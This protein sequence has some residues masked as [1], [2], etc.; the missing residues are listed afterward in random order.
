MT[1]LVQADGGWDDG[2]PDFLVDDIP[3]PDNLPDIV[4]LSDGRT[5]PVSVVQTATNS[6]PVTASNLQVQLTANFPAGFVYLVVPDP[7]HGQFPLQT[8]L[9]T[10][11]TSFLTNDFWQTDRT[12]GPQGLPPVLETNLHLFVYHTNAG[13]DTYNIVY[14]IPT[15]VLVTNPPVSSVFALPPQSPPMFGVV[16][17][18]ASYAGGS[19]IAYYDIYVS[20]NGGSFTDWQGHTSGTGALYNGV[21]GHTYAF[22]SIATDAA[23]HR[24]SPPLQPQAVT[25]ITVNTNPPTLSVASNATLTAGQTL[26]LNVTASDPNPLSPLTFSLGA[27]APAGVQFNPASGQVTW[28]TSPAFGGTTNLLSIVVQDNGQPPLSATGTVTVVLLPAVYPPV[29][30]VQQSGNT[31][32]KGGAS[33]AFGSVNLGA[34]LPESFIINNGGFGALVLSNLAITGGNAGDFQLSPISLPS[35]VNPAGATSFTVTFTPSRAGPESA[36]LRLTDNDTNNNP[37]T[38]ALIGTGL[39]VPPA[40][41]LTGPTNDTGFVTPINLTLS[42]TATETDGAVTNVVF[43]R[44]ATPL[45]NVPITPF[46]FTLTNAPA[47]FY[48]LTAV[49]MDDSGASSTSSVVNVLVTNPPPV[50]GNAYYTRAANAALL[51]TISDL[52][53]N[54]TGTNGETIT[55]VGV[56]T[57]GLNLLSTNGTTLLNN[58]RYILYTNSVTPGVNDRFNYLVGDGQGGSAMG[59]VYIIV[60]NNIIGQSNVRL[61]FTSTNV[62]ANFFGVPGFKY[63]AERSTNLSVGLGWVP[64]STNVAPTNGL[65]QVTDGFQDLGIPIPPLPPQVFYLLRASP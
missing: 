6:G 62:T 7:A 58:G 50:A 24:E 29:L 32:L 65:I 22:Y 51:I 46:T 23:G 43:Y 28:A 54:V 53:T 10:N 21:N 60:N 16:W 31:L 12:F 2:L 35:V 17:S 37:F 55:L 8:V 44:G 63:T 52:L 57:D 56:G 64:I 40:V 59:T 14:R 38:V 26:S 41:T 45:G 34:N 15:N 48:A 5:Q 11:G 4:Y 27:G 20:D 47:G 61:T 33:V 25:A 18:G 42:A 1:H 13:P 36:T 9:Y 19:P 30:V 49:A 39:H 3:N